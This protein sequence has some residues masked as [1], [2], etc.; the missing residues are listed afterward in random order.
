MRM[1]KDCAVGVFTGL[2]AGMGIALLLAPKSGSETRS[3]IVNRAREGTDDL[4]KKVRRL[5]ASARGL[6]REGRKQVERRLAIL[7]RALEAGTRAFNKPA[8]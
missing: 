1:N 2:S 3:A 7:D 8:R 4:K 5:R 6:V